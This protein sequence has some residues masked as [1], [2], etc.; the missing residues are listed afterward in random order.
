MRNTDYWQT[1]RRIRYGTQVIDRK[2][3]ESDTAHRW[4]AE[5]TSNQ[6][7]HTGNWQ[8][9]VESDTAHR[10]LAENTSNQMGDTGYWQ[11]TRR[12]R[13]EAPVI[14]RQH[15]E[16]NTRHRLLT[17]NNV[18]TN[19]RH[20]L[21]TDNNVETNTRHRLLTD[22]TSKKTRDTGYWQ[23][24]RPIRRETPVTDRQHIETNARHWLLTDNTSNQIQLKL[25][26]GRWRRLE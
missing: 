23:I 15:A 17:D 21:L 7:R 16:T 3:V 18:E 22:N 5:N 26:K 10:W 12:I 19:K 6:I 1:T 20:R 24:T 9:T 25:Y 14:E 13:C 4:L 11:T 8:K 2:H